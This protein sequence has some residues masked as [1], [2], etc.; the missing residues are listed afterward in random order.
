MLMRVTV[1]MSEQ[2]YALVKSKAGLIPLSRWIKDVV[3]NYGDA[4][5][6]PGENLIVKHPSGL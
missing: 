4:K 6:R 5:P 1:I 2:E 3:L